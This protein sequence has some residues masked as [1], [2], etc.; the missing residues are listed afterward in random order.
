M[1]HP[2]L[3]HKIM[4]I[5]RNTYILI[6]RCDIDIDKDG[7]LHRQIWSQ[8]LT[9]LNTDTL[10]WRHNG[11]DGVSSHQSPHGLLN[12]L[13]TRR[14]KTTSKLRVTGLWPVNSPHKWGPVMRKM[15]PFDDVIMQTSTDTDRQRIAMTHTLTHAWNIPT[16]NYVWPLFA[17]I[18]N[19]TTLFH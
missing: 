13:F 11:R 3:L 5:R 15:F 9:C 1:Y 8:T 4:D 18:V 10:Q 2:P 12:R 16:C 17:V 7:D 14:S 19:S 6:T